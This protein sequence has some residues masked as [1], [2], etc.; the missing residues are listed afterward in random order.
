MWP[1]KYELIFD[2][3]QVI[4][5][6]FGL[7]VELARLAANFEFRIVVNYLTQHFT[8]LAK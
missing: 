3:G 4:K 8:E 1:L 6:V 5:G 2:L 7:G